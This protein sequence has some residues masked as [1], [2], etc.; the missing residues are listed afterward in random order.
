MAF[1]DVIV[2]IRKERSLSQEDFATSLFVT[3]QAVSRWENGETMPTVDTLKAIAEKYEVDAAALLG[4]PEPPVCQSCAMPMADIGDFGTN[5]G[6]TANIEYC[7]HCYGDGA[8]THSRT[9]EEMVESNLRFLEEFN[10]Q[11]GTS[12]S[13]DEARTILKMHLATLKRWQ[14]A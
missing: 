12:Y 4:L 6:G 5:E 2:G 11:N 9:I 10:A 3:R 1:Q 7:N 14:T 8:F 13:E